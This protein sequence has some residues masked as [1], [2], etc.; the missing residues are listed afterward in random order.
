MQSDTTHLKTPTV[1]A[2]FETAVT[3]KEQIE[4][5]QMAGKNNLRTVFV[6]RD[7]DFVRKGI[8]ENRN[9]IP[10]NQDKALKKAPLTSITEFH[11]KK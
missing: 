5:T 9:N 3:Q 2:R 11:Q 7:K 4:E 10:K 6:L 1:T 8:T